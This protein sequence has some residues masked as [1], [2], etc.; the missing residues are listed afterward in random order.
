MLIK[1]FH[2][3]VPTTASGNGTMRELAPPHGPL[4]SE[5]KDYDTAR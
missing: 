1:E 4:P 3:D 2:K 5:P